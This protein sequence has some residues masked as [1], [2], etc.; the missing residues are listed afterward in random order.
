MKVTTIEKELGQPNAL[1]G[2]LLEFR[3][4]LTPQLLMSHLLVGFIRHCWMIPDKLPDHDHD[5]D[6]DD[7]PR[8][9]PLLRQLMISAVQQSLEKEGNLLSPPAYRLTPSP[10]MKR[11]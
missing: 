11:S 6:Q 7:H 4:F 5:A 9:D 3:A 2:L 10:T 1:D 8:Q